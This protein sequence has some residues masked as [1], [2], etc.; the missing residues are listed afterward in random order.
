M[1]VTDTG[2]RDL[3][4]FVH[5]QEQRILR[6]YDPEIGHVMWEIK[7]ARYEIEMCIAEGLMIASEKDDER[8]G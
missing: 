1:R 7:G 8:H 2:Y 5:E 3:A 4:Q 6:E